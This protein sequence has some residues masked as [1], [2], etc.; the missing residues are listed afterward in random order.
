MTSVSNLASNGQ[1]DPRGLLR[2]VEERAP[3]PVHRILLHKGEARCLQR[4]LCSKEPA[5]TVQMKGL[6]GR[7]WGPIPV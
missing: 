5:E 6:I 2:I 3:R 4:A 7:V 1:A